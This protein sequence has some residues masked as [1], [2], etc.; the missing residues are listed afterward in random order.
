MSSSQTAP[1]LNQPYYGAPLGAA[2]QRF[3]KKY[4]TFT[5]RA[6]RSEFWWWIL[7]AAIVNLVLNILATVGGVGVTPSG[8]LTVSGFGVFVLVVAGLWSL[9]TI[10]P[11]I[12]VGVRRLHDTNHSGFWYF[13]ALVPLLGPIVLLVFFLRDADPQGA[14][15]D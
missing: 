6:S 8:E 3:F 5:G 9:A 13:I 4:A 15:F 11:Q 1:A 7:I 2:V 10:V 14:R 12:A